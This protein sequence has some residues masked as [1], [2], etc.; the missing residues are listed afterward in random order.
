MMDVET[1]DTIA[2]NILAFRKVEVMDLGTLMFMML[3]GTNAVIMTGNES[4]T[5]SMVS[6]SNLKRERTSRESKSC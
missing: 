5:S 3:S 6:G 1:I 2:R 4:K